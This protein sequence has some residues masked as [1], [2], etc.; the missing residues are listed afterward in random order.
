LSTTS[1]TPSGGPPPVADSTVSD[2]G[3]PLCSLTFSTTGIQVDDSPG[4]TY[5]IGTIDVTVT[6]PQASVDASV[7][8]D[9]TSTATIVATGIAATFRFN[10]ATRELSIAP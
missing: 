3:P 1:G 10:L 9:G 5:P 6:G 8:F 7:T 2:N 4:Q